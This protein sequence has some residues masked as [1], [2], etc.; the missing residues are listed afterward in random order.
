[1]RDIIL[2]DSIEFKII[3]GWST[4][5]ISEC[6]KIINHQTKEYKSWGIVK[7][8]AKG[9]GGGYRYTRLLSDSGKSQ[10]M[11][12]HRLMLLAWRPHPESSRLVVNHKNGTPGDDCLDNLEWCTRLENNRH[13]F[14]TGLCSN[15][16]KP[17]LVRD[18]K[19]DTITR[20]PSITHA[21][22]AHGH[23]RGD[24]W[25]ARLVSLTK[26]FRIFED[27]LL[28]KFDDG[29]PWPEIND[30][31]IRSGLRGVP[32]GIRAKNVLTGESYLFATAI[33]AGN[34]LGLNNTAIIAHINTKSISPMK[35]YCFRYVVDK[36]PMPE[37]DEWQLLIIKEHLASSRIGSGVVSINVENN[38]YTFYPVTQWCA[39]EFGLTR[40]SLWDICRTGKTYKNHQFIR[41]SIF[42]KVPF[43]SNAE[44]EKCLIAG[45]G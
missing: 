41:I 32:K 31:I 10:C 8:N 40:R 22:K 19:T 18:L 25:Q 5:A 1:M 34:A 26:R 12:R 33:A 13:A 4:Y 9:W 28:I 45:K 39:D 17:V 14:N 29:S 27:L 7:P 37:F 42:D 2:H 20:Y 11:L 16:A 38:Q 6:Q 24:T 3:P 21:A 35:G 36:D 15:R 43:S 44:R 30:D 23:T